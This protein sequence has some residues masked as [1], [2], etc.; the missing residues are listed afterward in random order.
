MG[1]PGAWRYLPPTAL[2]QISG[3]GN[4]SF[5][6]NYFTGTASASSRPP[7]YFPTSISRSPYPLSPAPPPFT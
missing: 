4:N 2:A 3:K 5:G 6:P 7:S 1:S